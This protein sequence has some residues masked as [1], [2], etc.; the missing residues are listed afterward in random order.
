M[1]KV[2]GLQE[3]QQNLQRLKEEM[4]QEFEDELET[5]G[6]LIEAEAKRNAPVDTGK[7]RQSIFY[8]RVVRGG[9]VGFAVTA[10]VPYAYYIEFGTGAKVDI[11]DGWG[12]FAAQFKGRGIRQVNMPARPYLIPAYRNQ[13]NELGKRLETRVKKKLSLFQRVKAFIR[14]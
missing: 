8:E 9:R 7:L 12:D 14:R 13:V 3:L 2:H 4:P 5:T 1:I 11:P 10:N 6:R